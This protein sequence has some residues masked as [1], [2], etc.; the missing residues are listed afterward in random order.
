MSKYPPPSKQAI[1]TAVR[2]KTN[3][4]QRMNWLV[5]SQPQPKLQPKRQDIIPEFSNS[6]V[7]S[8][9]P[10]NIFQSWCSLDLPPKMKENVELLKIQNPEF[11]YYLY[12]D[13][14]SE[15]FI[16]DNFD[17]DVVYSFNKLKPGAYKSDLWRLCIL[18]IK[19]GIYLDIKYKCINGF[20]LLSLTDNE[21]YV[22]DRLSEGI[23]GIYNGF[24][25]SM[26]NN[27]RLYK[28]IQ[29]IVENVKNNIYGYTALFPTG[30]H[31]LASFFNAID[32]NALKL[33]F[34]EIGIILNNTLILNYYPEYR[35][36]QQ[37]YGL[38]KYYK[39]L[40]LEKDIYNYPIL[41]PELSTCYTQTITKTILNIPTKLYSGTPCIIAIS[42]TSYLVNLRWVNYKI[43]PDGSIVDKP[44]Q[45]I[46]LNS[47]FIVDSN[48]LKISDEIFLEEDFVKEKIY[49]GIGL[50]DIRIFN[51]NNKYYYIS[52]RFDINRRLTSTSSDVYTLD[53]TTYTL[54]R[55]II[56]PN[57]Y[58]LHKFFI[59]EKN[60]NFVTLNNKLCVIYNWFPIQIGEIDYETNRLNITQFKYNIPNFFKDARGSTG[61]CI[62]N[63]EIW[64]VL[65]KAQTYFS[66]NKLCRN[67]Q[68]FFAV[69]DS[70]MNLI[71]FSELFKFSNY[72][73]EFCVG[74][75]VKEDSIILSYS[76]MDTQSM[77]SVYSIDWIG[78][79]LK[80]YTE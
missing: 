22:S 39:T 78:Q 57:T 44:K 33:R 77:V 17:E 27:K 30:P 12:D 10:L 61:G 75:I 59:Y 1:Q 24:I 6:K 28:G 43:N 15:Q 46:S 34:D 47:R 73:I 19:G 58:D 66:D 63:N 21:Y 14:T 79:Q 9:I 50:E 4:L 3:L 8:I 53:E 37:K 36:E 48:F 49:D 64:F 2:R 69:F 55:N 13:E 7:Y 68:H 18:Y 31:S 5:N 16:R 74:L 70:D 45:W 41:T 62:R 40:W 60:W 72:V 42:D 35:S 67:Y 26:P 56:L 71:R 65:H 54:N 23:R 20:K 32:V 29:Q 25:V 52:T 11:T 51:F 76:L 38:L 80:W